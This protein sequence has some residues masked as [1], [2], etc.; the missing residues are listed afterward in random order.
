V[1]VG[2]NFNGTCF[3]IKDNLLYFSKPQQPEYW[4]ALYYLEIS[5]PQESLTGLTLY[6]GQVYVLTKSDIYLVQGTGYQSFFP[7]RQTALTGVLAQDGILALRGKGVLRVANDGLWGA[8]G[9]SDDN[10]TNPRFRQIFFGETAGT[11]PGINRTY[12]VNSWIISWRN[13]LYHA[14]PGGT[15]VYPGQILVTDLA[16]GKTQ[17]Y[18]YGVDFATATIDI[19]N[20]RILAADTSGYIWELEDADLVSDAGT[21]IS[22]D[23]QSGEVSDQLRQYFPRSAKYDVEV[24]SGTAVAHV[25]LDGVSKQ[26]HTLSGSRNSTK[27]LVDTCTGKRLQCRITGTGAVSIWGAELE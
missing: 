11:I 27:R 14:Y 1:V 24:A 19:V 7:L 25:M 18:D 20:D 23:Y 16:T 4:P 3:I 8:T 15:E 2:P 5:S 17:H 13:K 26:Q 6:G 22:W 21:A 12:T 10:L 9:N